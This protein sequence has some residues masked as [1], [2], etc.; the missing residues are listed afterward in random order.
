MKHIVSNK[1]GFYFNLQ[2]DYNGRYRSVSDNYSG[3]SGQLYYYL[4]LLDTNQLYN[5]LNELHDKIKIY[6][7]EANHGN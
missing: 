5:I 2:D 7:G 1:I 4:N 6:H 3:N